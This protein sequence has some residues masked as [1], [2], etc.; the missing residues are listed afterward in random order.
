[1][2]EPLVVYKLEDNVAIL[3]LNN[4]TWR[5]ALSS[6]VLAALKDRLGSIMKDSTIKVVVLP[7]RRA[8][9]QLGA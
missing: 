2:S 9:V 6:E 5:H 4:P 7:L 8:G 3:K 1:M